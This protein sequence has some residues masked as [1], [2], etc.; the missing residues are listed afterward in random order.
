MAR[1]KL[2]SKEKLD[3]A[4]KIFDLDGDGFI[5]KAELA[6][7]MGGIELDD[8]A[9]MKLVKEVDSNSDGKISR[10]EF[11]NLLTHIL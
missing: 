10:D 2:F 7:V 9:W 1:E 11:L 3:Q 6:N 8:N 4:F 5:T